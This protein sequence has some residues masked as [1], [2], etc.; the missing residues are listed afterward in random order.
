M[1]NG[2]SDTHPEAEAVQIR[3]LREATVSRRFDL[4]CSLTRTAIY[5]AKRAIERANPGITP[6]ERDLKYIELNYGSEL[7]IE[8]R[9]YLEQREG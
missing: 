2:L 3:L 7:A 8:V 9:R 6:R 4:L 1:P 5:H